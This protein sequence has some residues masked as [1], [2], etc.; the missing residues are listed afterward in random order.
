MKK[1][2]V[3]I[4]ISKDKLD[5]CLLE[6]STHKIFRRGVISNDKS[7]ILKW[8]KGIDSNSIEL[9]MEHTGHYGALLAWILSKAQCT[10]FLI[11]P[12]ELKHSMGIQRGKTDKVD[13][14]RIANYTISNRYKLKPYILP[15]EEISKLKALASAR[16]RHNKISVQ[17]QN[18]IKNNKILNKTVD[19]RELIKQEQVE[20]KLIKETLRKLEKQMLAIIK[21]SPELKITYQKIIK[22][23]GVGPITAMQTIAETNNFLNF[24]DPRKFC[25]HSG[26]APFPHESGKSVKGRKKTNHMCKKSLKG[27]F[28]KAAA[29]A[30]QHDPQLK[31]YYNRKLAEGKKKLCVLNA[32]ANKIILRIFAVMKREEDFVKLAA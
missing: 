9:A 27:T 29:S 22:V 2:T 19:V 15:T 28:Y 20:L 5:Y 8:L 12:L 30:I 18:S 31:L 16:R 25:C 10:F 11:N 7:A 13:A 3:G 23:I 14:Y 1:F 32:V 6:N 24:N 21:A 17:L 26:L 4:D